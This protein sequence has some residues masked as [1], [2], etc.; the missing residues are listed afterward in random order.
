MTSAARTDL[1]LGI[2]REMFECLLRS[3]SYISFGETNEECKVAEDWARCQL[4]RLKTYED[5]EHLAEETRLTEARLATES[6]Q[7]VTPLGFCP[8][9]DYRG[10]VNQ[11]DSVLFGSNMQPRV[12]IST[13]A[14]WPTTERKIQPY[15]LDCRG[16]DSDGDHERPVLKKAARTS[17]W[18]IPLPEG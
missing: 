15:E 17:S 10:G 1:R 2:L 8:H 11:E 14:G 7:G 5:F 16:M 6:I 9:D 13:M 4:P 3:E 12:L 18:I